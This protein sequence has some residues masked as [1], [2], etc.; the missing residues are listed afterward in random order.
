[1]SSVRLQLHIVSPQ[2]HL[3]QLRTHRY[4]MSSPESLKH[5]DRSADDPSAAVERVAAGRGLVVQA[6]GE[7]SVLF[8]WRSL[9]IAIETP[10]KRRGGLQQNNDRTRDG[11]GGHLVVQAVPPPEIAGSAYPVHD[12]REL[13]DRVLHQPGL[14]QLLHD[15]PAEP[16]PVPAVLVHVPGNAI[17]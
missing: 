13:R 10:T 17:S 9:S 4:T 5:L 6:V 15:A 3:L 12:G 16:A 2:L 7:S 14:D 11:G 8:C 1:M